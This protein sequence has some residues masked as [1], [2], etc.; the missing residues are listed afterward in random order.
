MLR[1]NEYSVMVSLQRV[2]KSVEHQYQDTHL[3]SLGNVSYD[4]ID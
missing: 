1:R 4:T 2:R 3:P